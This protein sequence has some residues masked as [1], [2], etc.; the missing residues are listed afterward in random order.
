[1][2]TYKKKPD[3]FETEEG[4]EARRALQAMVSNPAYATKATYSPN[5]E[6]Y[7]DKQVPF[8]DKHMSYLKSHPA[9]NP[10][11]YLS[12]LRLMTRISSSR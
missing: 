9:T 2:P 10:S 3:F 11:Q 12:N 8:I 5:T 4:I 1:M 6:L 7:P